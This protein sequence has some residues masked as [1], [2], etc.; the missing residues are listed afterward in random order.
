MFMP[1]IFL[2]CHICQALCV[3]AC[4]IHDPSCFPFYFGILLC[5]QF[6]SPWL[7]QCS[8]LV[9]LV[10]WL[11]FVIQFRIFLVFVWPLVVPLYFCLCCWWHLRVRVLLFGP[12]SLKC[13]NQITK[14]IIP[15]KNWLCSGFVWLN[16]YALNQ[17]D[18]VTEITAT[19]KSHFNAISFQNSL[20]LTHTHTHTLTQR[21]HKDYYSMVV[22]DSVSQDWYGGD[23]KITLIWTIHDG[24]FFLLVEECYHPISLVPTYTW[25]THT[26]TCSFEFLC[27]KWQ[28]CL[29]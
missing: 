23:D 29:V 22:C 20:S 13:D 3:F 7:R 18:V 14:T 1:D 2:I 8:C 17:L 9:L 10:I 19:D 16:I 15:S 5:C 11:F 25:Q 21:S 27:P 28:R 26:Q 24:E 12:F 6:I 4:V